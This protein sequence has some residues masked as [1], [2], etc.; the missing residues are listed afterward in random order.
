MQQAGN[1]I[2]GIIFGVSYLP[3]PAQDI[4]KQITIAFRLPALPA[5]GSSETKAP[6]RVSSQFHTTSTVQVRDECD[7]VCIG[8]QYVAGGYVRLCSDTAP[9][10]QASSDCFFLLFSWFYSMFVMGRTGP[11]FLCV[12]RGGHECSPEPP[13]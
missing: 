4:G 12:G 7:V 10:M 1:A 2:N 3:G 5:E 9:L 11:L 6:S 8:S 13:A